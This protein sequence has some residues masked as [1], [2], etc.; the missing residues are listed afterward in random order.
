MRR[1]RAAVSTVHA[2]GRQPPLHC[3]TKQPLTWARAGCDQ[4]GVKSGS[5]PHGD[6]PSD[7]QEKALSLISRR[8]SDRAKENGGI[9]LMSPA[10]RGLISAGLHHRACPAVL[11]GPESRCRVPGHGCEWALHR[12]VWV[13]RKRQCE[14]VAKQ[15]TD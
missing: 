15:P 11:L 1:A 2:S 12:D 14:G 3:D 13:G 7:K 10:S 8:A 6:W 9:K 5:A 4:G